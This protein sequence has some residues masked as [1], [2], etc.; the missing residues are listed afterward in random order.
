M[1]GVAG[2]AVAYF[3]MVFAVAFACGALKVL[4]LAPR[5]GMGAG[6]AVDLAVV[7][8]ASWGVAGWCVRRFAV[9]ATAR[10]RAAMG[11]LAFAL[12]MAA[13]AGLA[14]TIGGGVAGWVDGFATALGAAGLA[15]QVMFAAIPLLRGWVG[16][17]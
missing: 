13:E 9:P 7:L 15:G 1:R 8:A 2:A 11:G 17:D 10:Q 6:V 3:V 14:A 12:L 5:F 16:R 4:V